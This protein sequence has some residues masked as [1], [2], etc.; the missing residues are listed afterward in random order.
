[1]E[2]VLRLER[3]RANISI[4]NSRR[5]ESFGREKKGKEG[6]MN[7]MGNGLDSVGRTGG[8]G[9]RRRHIITV[10]RMYCKQ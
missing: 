8:R 6:N 9:Q 3:E 7:G 10:F 2:A 1:M 4:I 5:D